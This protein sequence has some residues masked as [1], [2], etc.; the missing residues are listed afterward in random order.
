MTPATTTPTTLLAF[1]FGTQFIGVAVGQTVTASAHPLPHLR[2]RDGVPDWQTLLQLIGAWRPGL[3]LVGLPLN[4]DDSDNHITTRARRFARQLQAR[5]GLP[6]RL[7]DERLSTV[8]ARERIHEHHRAG[9]NA[10]RDNVD[11]H[12]VAAQLIAENWLRAPAQNWPDATAMPTD[13]TTTP[14]R[15]S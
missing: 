14:A 1:D 4:M 5:S 6:T 9:I 15:D 2:A 8:A 13:S 10:R 11:S 12:G 7:I 3:L